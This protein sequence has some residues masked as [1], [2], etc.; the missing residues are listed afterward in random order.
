MAKQNPKHTGKTARGVFPFTERVLVA[1]LDPRK[2]HADE[3]DSR[4]AKRRAGKTRPVYERDDGPL[5]ARQ[6]GAIKRLAPQGR[7]KVKASLFPEKPVQ[8]KL[9]GRK[10][11]SI[12]LDPSLTAALRKRARARGKTLDKE[13]LDAVYGHLVRIKP[14]DLKQFSQAVSQVHRDLSAIAR[15][16]DASHLHLAVLLA[17]LKN[18]RA[19]RDAKTDDKKRDALQ[20][21]L[22]RPARRNPRLV[23]LL[24]TKPPWD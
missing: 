8:V 19:S 21:M 20:A 7:M 17:M 13:A 3:W 15:R 5:T 6:I 10:R 24:R 1:G 11:V 2:A 12:D 4:T 18:W 23:R 9:R 16:V 22:D 14:Q